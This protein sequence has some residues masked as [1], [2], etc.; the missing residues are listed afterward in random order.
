MKKSDRLEI[1]RKGLCRDAQRKVGSAWTRQMPKKAA[2]RLRNEAAEGT[3]LVQS[4]LHQT[5]SS[6]KSPASLMQADL[7]LSMACGGLTVCKNPAVSTASGSRSEFER[8]RQEIRNEGHSRTSM[9]WDDR[10]PLGALSDTIDRLQTSGY[11]PVF[12]LM[13]DQAWALCEQLFDAMEVIMGSDVTLDTSLFAW[14]LQRQQ[15]Q[16]VEATGGRSKAVVKVSSDQ[17]VGN[18]FGT[19]HR[20][21]RYSECH[22]ADGT[23]TEISCWVPLV[24]VTTDNGCMMLVPAQHDALFAQSDHPLHMKPAESMPWAHIRSLPAHAGEVLLWQANTIHWGSSCGERAEV[25]RKS[26]AMAFTVPRD[27]KPVESG[28]IR[29]AD[30]QAGL[31]LAQRVKLVAKSLLTY[32]HWHPSFDGFAPSVVEECLSSMSFR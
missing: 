30:L 10:V 26:I 13:Y 18:N 23:P 20:D 5:V 1:G 28:S 19:P 15:R 22:S 16:Q 24:D 11:P 8:V 32:E 27:G 14:A 3:V 31:S 6:L 17:L 21:S 4:L 9:Q 12:I 7:W 25:P 29:R 2:S